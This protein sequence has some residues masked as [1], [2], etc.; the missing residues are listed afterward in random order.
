MQVMQVEVQ[1]SH[2]IVQLAELLL[3]KIPQTLYQ[4]LEGLVKA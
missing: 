2:K 3:R 1:T 4:T